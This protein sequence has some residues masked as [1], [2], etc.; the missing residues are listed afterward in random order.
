M[1]G[2][3]MQQDKEEQ[4]LKKRLTELAGLCWQRDIQTHSGFL[5]LR[6]QTVF[7]S[8]ERELAPVRVLL[9]GGYPQAERKMVC[10]LASYEEESAPLPIRVLSVVPA[11]PRFA[12]PLTHRDYLGAVMNLGIERSCVGDILAE[13][14]GCFIF[15]LEAMEEFLCRELTMVGRTP[16]VCTPAERPEQIAP[17]RQPVGGSVASVRLDNV[18]AMVFNLPRSRV[19]P[20]IEGERAFIDGRLE[21]SA[22]ARLSGGEV[23]S[24]RGLGKFQYLG[25]QKETKKGRLYVRAE[26]YL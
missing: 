12:Q 24:V 22:S 18:I 1:A 6:E 15:C 19:A 26:K 4:L 17:R 10:F 13:E 14:N 23:V 2:R 3:E 25:E 16:V 5:T 8:I 21:T 7:H 11:A 9:A 20:Y